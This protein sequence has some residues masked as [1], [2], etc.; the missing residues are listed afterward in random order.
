MSESIP[1]MIFTDEL[2]LKYNYTAGKTL[3]YFFTVLR[4]E[5]IILGK[6]CPE[7]QQ[8][9]FPPR[10]ICGRCYADTTDWVPLSGKGVLEAY[11]VVR[12]T[13]PTLPWP[14]P[15][16]FGQIKLTGTDGGITYLIKGVKPE[17]IQIGMEVQA[18]LKSNRNGN[19]HDIEC[20]NPI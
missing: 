15:Y 14:A 13:E 8:V 2:H 9:L 3:S 1:N 11:T 12:Y 10:K 20:F 16:I 7:C 4:D 6:K 18:L 19:L 5:G 17:E